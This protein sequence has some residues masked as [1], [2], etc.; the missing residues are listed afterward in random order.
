MDDIAYAAQ[1]TINIMEKLS[2]YLH[3]QLFGF[4]LLPLLFSLL[5]Y[6]SGFY[7]YYRHTPTYKEVAQPP[8]VYPLLEILLFLYLSCFFCEIRKMCP[9]KNLLAIHKSKFPG[10]NLFFNFHDPIQCTYFLFTQKLT[11][12]LPPNYRNTLFAYLVTT[13]LYCSI[14][15]VS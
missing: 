15:D 1:I 8:F 9:N 3:L 10:K 12:C 6:F 13:L 7:L 5:V 4:P 2:P 14:T 11:F